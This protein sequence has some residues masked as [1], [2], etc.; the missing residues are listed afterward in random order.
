MNSEV[1]FL[2]NLPI[3]DVLT[4]EVSKSRCD[5]GSVELC[6]RLGEDMLPREVV[7]EFTAIAVLHNK[8]DM[9]PRGEGVLQLRHEG[10][11]IEL[12]HPMLCLCVTN[13]LFLQTDTG[14]GDEH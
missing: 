1:F 8:E 2:D 9:I 5:F 12:Q 13:L 3:D 10:M 6:S 14:K 11:V 7:E 4:M